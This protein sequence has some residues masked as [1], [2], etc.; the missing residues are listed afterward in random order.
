MIIK[1]GINGFG[2]I[3]RTIFKEAKKR[4]NLQVVAINDEKKYD[5]IAYLLKYDSISGINDLSVEIIKEDLIVDGDFIKIFSYK[6]P[7]LINWGD[8]NV[9]IVIESSG[10]FLTYNS[11]F[12]HLNSGA[13]KVFI[14]TIP[15]DNKIPI[16]VM[17]IN[18][19]SYQDEKI[20]SNASS[21]THCLG[22]LSK[23]LDENFGIVEGLITDIHSFTS[24]KDIMYGRYKPEGIHAYQNI[25]PYKTD[26]VKAIE[27]IIP[28]LKRKI[29]GR[30]F[31]VPVHNNVSLI[32]LT[33]KLK[34][35]TNINEIYDYIKQAAKH[36]LKGLIGYNKDKLVSS[37][38]KYNYFTSIFD[39]RASVGL[40]DNFFKLIAWYDN[41]TAFSSKVLDFV[42]FTYYK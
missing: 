33:V 19:D 10:R 17:G 11:N 18:H 34:K 22:I 41:E 38:F 24:I 40:N 36:S 42:T 15:K 25:I 27:K 14:T 31:L 3:G 4:T 1:I 9:D 26:F 23:F 21:T 5:Y 13:K 28:N 39:K 35:Q 2:R 16:F 8:Y 6:K 29:N 20:I 30:T 32:D 7:K 37:D 12:Q